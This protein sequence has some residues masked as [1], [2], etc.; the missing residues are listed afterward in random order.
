[1]GSA[2]NLSHRPDLDGADARPGNPTSDADRVVEIL[3]IDQEVAGDLLAR[4]D[5][6][7]VGDERFAVAH[8]ND[9]R[10]RR[11]LQRRCVDI[12]PLGVK[13]VRELHGLLK[14]LL[15]LGL[16]E[17]AEGLFVV[18]NQQHVFHEDTSIDIG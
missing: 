13:L 16:A 14:H 2:R 6:R 18:V 9:G 10:G 12:L 11:R 7:T 15:L 8:P 1:M 17:L 5:E 3:G 4:F